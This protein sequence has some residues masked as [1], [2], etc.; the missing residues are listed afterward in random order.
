MVLTRRVIKRQQYVQMSI[1]SCDTLSVVTHGG[2]AVCGS[3]LELRI[4]AACHVVAMPEVLH[5]AL[6]PLLAG[7]YPSSELCIIASEWHP[8]LH[9]Q[10]GLSVQ[11]VRS[12]LH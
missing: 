1:C 8:E 2:D 3:K 5:H 9:C 4:S 10:P 11:A 7:L 12:V 6:H